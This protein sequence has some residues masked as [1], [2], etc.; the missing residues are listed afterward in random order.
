MSATEFP[1][2]NLALNDEALAALEQSLQEIPA[3]LRER[4]QVYVDKLSELAWHPESG[5]WQAKVSGLRIYEVAVSLDGG[6]QCG[7]PQHKNDGRCKHTVAL[8]LRL[9]K[10]GAAAAL[11]AAELP[12]DSDNGDDDDETI[13]VSAEELADSAEASAPHDAAAAAMG[14]KDGLD[15]IRQI[16][17]GLKCPESSPEGSRLQVA[18]VLELFPDEGNVY[19]ADLVPRSRMFVKN[20]G[21]HLDPADLRKSTGDRIRFSAPKYMSPA[22]VQLIL[23]SGQVPGYGWNSPQIRNM[24]LHPLLSLAAETG[25]LMLPDETPLLLDK[26]LWRLIAAMELT[27]GLGRFSLALEALEKPSSRQSFQAAWKIFGE[28]G[29]WVVLTGS[30]LRRLDP[31]TPKA[32]F[33]LAEPL[34]ELPVEAL[35]RVRS[36]LGQLSRSG[37]TIPKE[38]LPPRRQEAPRRCLSIDVTAEGAVVSFL[39][40][41]PSLEVATTVADEILVFTAEDGTLTELQ[42]DLLAEDALRDELEDVLRDTKVEAVSGGGQWRVVDPTSLRQLA[43]HALPR[44]LK[45]EWDV[46]QSGGMDRWKRRSGALKTSGKASGQDWFELSGVVD[47]DGMEVPLSTLIA[48][49]GVIELPDGSTGDVSEAL[50]KRLRWLERLGTATEEGIRLQGFHAVLAQELLESGNA[51]A[52]D[53]STWIQQLDLAMGGTTPEAPVPTTLQA[54]LRP[55]QKQGIDWLLGLRARGIGGIL[56]DDMGLG[57]TVQVIAHL[58]RIYEADPGAAPALVVAPASVAGNWAAEVERFAPHL[59]TRLLHGNDREALRDAPIESPTIFVTTYGILARELEWL[60][61]QEF[62]LLVLDESQAIRNPTTTTHQ[63]CL[64]LK[65]KQKLCLTGTPI[66]NSLSD[67]WAQFAFLNPGLLGGREEFLNQFEPAQGEKPDLSRLRL[68][69]APF[70][71]RRTKALVAKDLPPREDIVLHVELDPKQSALYQRQLKEYQKN[72]LPEIEK[73]GLGE[74]GRFQVLTALLRLRQIA[75]APELAGFKGPAAKLDLLVDKLTEDI[76]EGHRALVF[77]SFTSLLDLVGMRLRHEALDFLRIDG[78]TPA[79][80]R[81]RLIQRFQSGKDAPIFLVSLKAGGAGINLTAAD[82]VFLLDP[83]WNPAAEA[84]AVARAHR[85]GQTRPVTLYRMVAKNTIEERVF[86]LSRS[87]AALASELFDAGETGGASLTAEV[88]S[89]LLG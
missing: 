20:E 85:I 65:A 34:P 16:G 1:D 76:A 87:K 14:V 69:T 54:T 41:Y 10:E 47:F 44:L 59:Q 7:C 38:C 55:Y 29:N 5:A 12:E 13:S 58:C 6:E 71:L 9:L 23:A 35:S 15:V 80:T 70:W 62:S 74:G 82:D 37:V 26:D 75:C 30:V 36:E 24:A 84:Q 86:A 25:R 19:S 68:L 60:Q 40:A 45:A 83:W 39:V 77:S 50:L 81:T 88:V 79:A 11:R 42:R 73:N 61:E 27:G 52:Q 89:Q 8:R 56:A 4:G 28:E 57:K 2:A 63:I 78:S 51:Q 46:R 72:L 48:S 67:L 32:L 17:E 49:S 43:L 21:W 64:E 33:A 31:R 53:P 3:L 66:E 22:D 18:Y